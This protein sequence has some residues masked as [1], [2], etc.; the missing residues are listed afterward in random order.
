M[1]FL[2]MLQGAK[3]IKDAKDSATSD[4][5]SGD[6]WSRYMQAAGAKGAQSGSSNDISGQYMNA[7]MNAQAEGVPNVA[8]MGMSGAQA[9]QVTAQPATL[10]EYI[11][12]MLRG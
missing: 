9:G 11:Q 3:A 12:R 2:A 1:N 7:G 6:V 4:S 10:D 5:D 8:Q